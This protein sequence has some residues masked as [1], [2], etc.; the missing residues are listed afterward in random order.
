RNLHRVFSSCTC[1]PRPQRLT[2]LHHLRKRLSRSQI[3]TPQVSG[4]GIRRHATSFSPCYSYVV[5]S[6]HMLTPSRRF[7][8]LVLASCM[9]PYAIAQQVGPLPPPAA[10]AKVD[11]PPPAPVKHAAKPEAPVTSEPPSIPPD[12]IVERFGKRESE[13]V[14]ERDK[15]VYTQ[16]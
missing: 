2:R 9:A 12:Q 5:S 3:Q 14:R 15:Y 1:Y 6:E 16:T 13:M 8:F 4:E 7:L 10:G 11:A